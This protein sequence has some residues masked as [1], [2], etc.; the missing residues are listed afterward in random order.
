MAGRGTG[1]QSAFNSQVASLTGNDTTGGVNPQVVVQYTSATQGGGAT[2][3]INTVISGATSSTMTIRADK[4]TTQEIKCKISHPTAA[5]NK[6]DADG[7]TTVSGGTLSGG[8]VTKTADFETISAINKSRSMVDWEV[9]DDITNS[10]SGF[11]Q[12][13]FLGDIAM[14]G[15]DNNPYRAFILSPPEENIAVKV[16][17]GGGKGKGYNGRSGGQGGTTVFTYTL[18]K[19]V[20]YVFKFGSESSAPP[21]ALG[22]GG[23]A[24]YFYEKGRL[25]VVC[26]A[27]GGSGWSGGNGGAGGGAS[28]S[29]AN[30]GGSSGGSG[31]QDISDGQLPSAGII[32]TGTNGGKIESCTTGVYWANQGKAPCEGLGGNDRFRTYD[33]TLVSSSMNI[34]RGYKAD[35]NPRN[36]F[37][38]NGGNSFTVE[39]GSYVGGGGAGAYGGNATT[40]GNSGGGGGSGYTNGSVAIQS[41]QQGGNPSETAYAIV[42]LV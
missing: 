10:R 11:S 25:L 30:G 21:D 28:V 31:G 33:G 24:A 18:Q 36:G 1:G 12:N 40:S 32:P 27:G 39:N 6:A 15:D 8:L 38:C 5:L 42:E 14:Q 2:Q 9:V 22:G 16:T 4:V 19:D 26:G 20:E 13:L 3:T 17:M 23:A 34:Q 29:G 41:T 35:N 37:R 7:S